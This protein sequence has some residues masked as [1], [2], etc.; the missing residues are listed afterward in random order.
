MQISIRIFTLFL[1]MYQWPLNSFLHSTYI[2]QLSGTKLSWQLHH[3]WKL[4][5]STYLPLKETSGRQWEKYIMRSSWQINSAPNRTTWEQVHSKLFHHTETMQE[6]KK[7]KHG[8]TLQSMRS[9]AS[10]CLNAI[11]SPKENSTRWSNM[12]DTKPQSCRPTEIITKRPQ[13]DCRF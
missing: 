13:T 3:T 12:K 5:F 9:Q 1:Q 6:D 7:T 8:E 4:S 2:L 11:T 10:F